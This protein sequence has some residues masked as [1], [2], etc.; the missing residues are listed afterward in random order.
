MSGS[1]TQLN[2][3][4]GDVWTVTAPPGVTVTPTDDPKTGLTTALNID[5]DYS[6]ADLNGAGQ[7]NS[8]IPGSKIVELSFTGP[9][10]DPTGMP[11]V[12]G[13]QY[14]G[15]IAPTTI[16]VT[17]DTGVPISGYTYNLIDNRVTL[18]SEPMDTSGQD[19]HPDDYAHFHN[20]T[21]TSLVN[22]ADDTFNAAV[23]VVDPYGNPAAFGPPDVGPLPA[24]STILAQGTI[25]PGATEYLFGADSGG[26]TL[27]SED[28]P[29]PHGGNFV[30]D[31]FPQSIVGTPPPSALLT[32]G[33]TM[34]QPSDAN[35]SFIFAGTAANTPPTLNFLGGSSTVNA[36][37]INGIVGV[38]ATTNYGN[39]NQQPGA[40]VEVTGGIQISNGSMTDAFFPGDTLTVDGASTIDNGGT[41]ALDGPGNF[42]L[43]GTVT[44]G[45]DGNNVLD[46]SQGIVSGGTIVQNGGMVNA[47]TVTATDFQVNGGALQIGG[48]TGFDGTIGGPSGPAIGQF[49][50]VNVFNAENVAQASLDTTTGLLTFQDSTGNALGSLQFAST[51]DLFGLELSRPAGGPLVIT[52][53]PGA[54]LSPI[55]IT[56]TT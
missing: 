40:N 45:A 4:P 49:G 41:F 13:G 43:N 23:S 29:G 48:L 11:V 3:G 7:P 5:I 42:V 12:P 54:S 34:F 44:V 2:D 16:E 50:E 52:D 56:F 28:T 6:Y 47:G 24:P 55:P 33:V 8:T 27:H 9:V 39:V 26:V 37:E 35:D 19:A 20:V 17:N 30:M 36:L 1:T 15:L 51:D 53:Q 31:I 21:D 46:V 25:Q 14:P 18:G 32:T 38:A 22:T 10:D